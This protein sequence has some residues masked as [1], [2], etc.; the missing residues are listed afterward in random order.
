[1][2]DAETITTGAIASHVKMVKEFQGAPGV[3][4]ER[5]QEGM[6]VLLDQCEIFK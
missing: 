2:D 5:I 4:P 1:M 6:Q 3:M